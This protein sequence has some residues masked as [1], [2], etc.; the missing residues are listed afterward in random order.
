MKKTSRQ[1]LDILIRYGILVLVAIPNLW[2]F[3]SIFTPLTAYPVVFL[4]SLFFETSFSGNI[5]SV[6]NQYSIEFIDACIAGSAYYLL[7]ILNLS[8]QKIR[9]QKRLKLIFLSFL[10]LLIIN[11]LRIF[12]LSFVFVSDLAWFDIAHKLLWYIGSIAF[13]V[14]IWF[15]EVKIFKIKEIPF[16][17]DIRFLYKKS[18]LR[19]KKR[20]MR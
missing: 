4:L 2:I 11:I 12:L 6:M 17:E 9:L 10:S 15:A 18:G 14:A 19:S 1:F 13:V 3:Y 7:L 20:R 5:V 8:I 16:Y